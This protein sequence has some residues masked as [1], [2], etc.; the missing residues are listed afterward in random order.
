MQQITNKHK[1][2][3]TGEWSKHPRPYLKRLGNKKLRRE[4]ILIDDRAI[5]SPGKKDKRFKK[6][7]LC[8]FCLDDIFLQYKETEIKQYGS[9]KKCF[10]VKTSLIA[11]PYCRSR[12]VWRKKTIF[13][14]KNCGKFFQRRET[15]NMRLMRRNSS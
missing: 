13:R 1:L 3:A 8:P 14:C 9:C 2:K 15:A 4:H 10:A 6:P 11:C 12:E 7:R 5:S